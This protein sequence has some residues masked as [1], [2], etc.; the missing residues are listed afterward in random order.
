MS[1]FSPFSLASESRDWDTPAPHIRSGMRIA[2]RGRVNPAKSF[3]SQLWQIGK[4]YVIK[5]SAANDA[6][7]RGFNVYIGEIKADLSDF[8]NQRP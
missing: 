5:N 2:A 1:F 4:S 6:N 7:L 3:G 8:S